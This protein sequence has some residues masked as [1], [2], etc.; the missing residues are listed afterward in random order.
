M[1]FK[2]KDLREIADIMIDVPLNCYEELLKKADES[3][4]DRI[5]AALIEAVHR[6]RAKEAKK[7]RKPDLP[8]VERG[9]IVKPWQ[10]FHF[11]TVRGIHKVYDNAGNGAQQVVHYSSPEL[12]IL[13]DYLWE[14]KRISE[15]LGHTVS[16]VKIPEDF[17]VR[18][19]LPRTIVKRE[20][21]VVSEIFFE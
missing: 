15:A 10:G 3:D 12:N 13:F 19:L 21:H 20:Y 11:T 2:D 1:K 6:R 8:F 4:R 14:A 17:P 16:T 7:I 18:T 5:V 9:Y